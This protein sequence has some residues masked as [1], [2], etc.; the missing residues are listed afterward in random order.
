LITS[1]LFQLTSVVLCTGWRAGAQGPDLG[2]VC[3]RGSCYPATGDLLIGRA[4]RLTA[5]STCGLS[6]P[7]R[8]CIVS[9]LQ[10]TQKCFECDSR[11]N[12]NKNH[13][14]SHNIENVVT[15]FTPDRLV[16]WW[17]S[18][19]GVENVTIQ[20]DLE[21][22]FHFTHLIMTFK[23]FRPAAMVI[24]R[25]MDNGNTWEVY[26]YF[27]YDCAT[28]FPG[29]SRGP[30]TKV[31][32]I[33]C[34]GRYSD[35]EPSTQGE[36]IFRVLD[37]AFE[38]ADPYSTR[39]QNLLKITNLRVRMERLHTMG[40]NLLDSREQL[41]EKYYY[42]LYDMVVRGN[43][44]CYGHAS[45]CAP[46]DWSEGDAEGMVHG[47]C[48][49]NHFTTGLNCEKCQDF[50]Q[51]LPWRPARGRNTNACK[52]CECNQHASTCHFD[53][54]MYLA[55]RNISGGVCDDCQHNTMGQHCEL[56]KPF[57]YQHPERDIRDP[58]ICEQCDCD[59]RGSL[60]GGVCDAVTDVPKGQIAGQCHC[61]PNVEGERCSECRQGYY[62]LSQSEQGCQQCTCSP[63]GTIPGGR[64]CDTETGNCFCKRFVTG[65]NCEQC[66][67]Q[68]WGLSNDMDGC[69]PCDC[70]K[71]GAIDNNCSA[72]TG[73][74]VCKE[75]IFGRRCDQVE[76]GF[77]F[78]SL[79][80][81]TYEAEEARFGPGVTVV[82]RTPPVNREPTWTGIGFAKVPEGEKMEFSID[83]TPKS[84]EYELLIRY[85]PQLPDEWEQLLVE[86][87]RSRPLEGQCSTTDYQSVSLRPGSRYVSLPWPV[88]FDRGQNYTVELSLPHYSSHSNHQSPYMYIDSMVLMPRVNSLDLFSG[89]QFDLDMFE[90]YRCL[91]HSR[92][93]VKARTTD[94]CR[95]Y[96][97]SL[98]A[99]LHQGT[100]GNNCVCDPTGSYSS[101]CDPDGGQCQCRTNVMGRSCNSC[102]P[103]YFLLGPSGCKSCECDPQ[104]AEHPFCHESTGQCTC[105]PGAYGRQ[106]AHCLPSHWGFPHCQPCQCNGHTEL[107]HPHTGECQGCKGHTT[108]HN[109]ERC[110][111]GYF[112]DALLGTGGQCRP[113]L[114]PEGPGSRRQFAEGCFQDLRSQKISCVCSPGYRGSR[115][116][117]CAPGF[118]GNPN[119]PGGRCQPCQCNG[120]IDTLD[121]E[122][123]DSRTGTCRKCLYHTQG[124]ACQYC[125]R[126]YYGD[127][128][129]QS[130]RRCMCNEIGTASHGCLDGECVCDGATGQCPCRPGVVGQNCDQCA[131]EMWNFE[132]GDGCQF[133]QC[134][135]VHSYGSSCNLLSGQC[136]CKPG[137]GGR[138]CDE[139]REL[140]WGNPEIKCH[141][142][143]CD[144]RGIASEQCNKMTGDCVCVEGVAGRRCDTCGRGYTGEFP[145]CEPC[146]QCFSSW[147][148]VVSEL[149]NHT[150][151]LLQLVDNIKVSGVT[152][153]YKVTI[154]SLEKSVSELTTILEHDPISEPLTHT[155]LL[156][157]DATYSLNHTDF[158]LEAVS[159]N[160]NRTKI[161]LDSV[162]DDA[163]KLDQTIKD[164]QEQV[165]LVKNSDIR[166]ATDSITKYYQHSIMA[167]VKANRS[168]DG[169]G[170]TVQQSAGLRQT[171]EDILKHSKENFEKRLEQNAQKMN[172]FASQLEALNLSKL[173]TFIGDTEGCGPCGG[174][175]CQS[176]DRQSHCG[177]EGCGGVLTTAK[178]AL[179]KTKDFDREITQGLEEVH[180]L[181]KMVTEARI[182]ADIARNSAHDVILKA[183][184]S[185]ERVELN[186]QE[187]R[188]LIQQIRDFLTNGTN[189][190]TIDALANEVLKIRLPV[191]SSELKSLTSDIRESVSGLTRVEDVLSQSA[192]HIARA[193]NLL[194][195]AKEASEHA[196]DIKNQA[197]QVKEALEESERAQSAV[198]NVTQQTK[199]VIESTN[200]QLTSVSVLDYRIQRKGHNVIVFALNVMCVA[201]CSGCEVM[202]TRSGGVLDAHR[203]AEDLQ[204]EAKALLGHAINSLERLRELERSYA[205][206]Q[207]I[208]EEKSQDL[209]VLEN[210]AQELLQEISQ[211]V[212]VYSTCA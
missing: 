88:C 211:K 160:H 167:E 65:R 130:C 171:T 121:P 165:E 125:K 23:T 55:S 191:S 11:E 116:D 52:R 195:S 20:L 209:E 86:V 79:D 26:R 186:N 161:K 69:R 28:S 73:H 173:K 158:T 176:E 9:H 132:S 56:C 179:T 127:A 185:K 53:M 94:I 208:L 197:D 76:S 104:G 166:G 206:N 142:C 135:P 174:I 32:D 169:P 117:E 38:I 37:P 5:S 122:A 126:G 136:S 51:D 89:S 113:C 155:K 85:E 44:F 150:Q 194:R 210:E 1:H 64:P 70:D 151:Y 170:S 203:R 33:I 102:S 193:Q 139:C 207:K 106:C 99:V 181:N 47:K 189:P 54:A 180:K 87:K 4:H 30:L 92:S 184:Q 133:C 39:I 128:R 205:V 134:H 60:H 204:Q 81:Y 77:Y 112:G 2:D 42:A 192:D 13:L 123:C 108:G 103:G 83:N 119:V 199:T 78:I 45:K 157:Q 40:D 7:E 107:C 36:V 12:Y 200:A 58:E 41:K 80:H 154:D 57:Y 91:E 175:G 84:M 68:H 15:T 131:S 168:T 22:E 115:C 90:R 19:N 10:E 67:P 14:N 178:D 48:V 196:T 59:P 109:C 105:V 143:D 16:T 129:L 63:L 93:V 145:N 162:K 159:E 72:L 212:S 34:D 62:G 17:Q 182:R 152:A 148:I 190:N 43:C 111:R 66:L 8:F 138:T 75:H 120:N 202:E 156:L 74:C 95:D 29:V 177:G 35:I 6:G 163:Q 183:I 188:E 18:E 164:L 146:H 110:E 27:A 153:P 147:N 101:I 49:C 149:T 61:K 82:P 201:H 31:D 46:T 98:S 114:C 96:V 21:A 25:S 100:M 50:Y 71:G 140:F 187:L 172:E 24:E 198:S 137:F 141:A 118:Y 124:T 144:P 97:F 3:A